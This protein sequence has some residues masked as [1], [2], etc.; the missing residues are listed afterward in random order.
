MTV[1]TLDDFGRE[2]TGYGRSFQG[3]RCENGHFIRV[4]NNAMTFVSGKVVFLPEEK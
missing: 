1:A 2:D 3:V 4:A